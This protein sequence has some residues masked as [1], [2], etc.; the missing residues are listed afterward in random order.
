M[1]DGTVVLREAVS[2]IQRA[3]PSLTDLVV[4]SLEVSL[5]A[6]LCAALLGLPLAAGLAAAPNRLR[7]VAVPL[8]RMAAALPAVLIG[9]LVLLMVGAEEGSETGSATGVMLAVGLGQA[10]LGLVVVVA[11]AEPVLRRGRE[12]LLKTLLTLGVGTRLAWWVLVREAR[13]GLCAAVAGAWVRVIGETGSALVL[14]GA[15]VTMAA[16]IVSLADQQDW[17]RVVALGMVLSVLA[18]SAGVLAV[19]LRGDGC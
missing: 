9:L 17:S 1:Q 14:G 8:F 2:L 6:T 3:D 18:I 13:R 16:A 5:V 10:A 11:L 19:K 12:R 4:R 7:S 15:G